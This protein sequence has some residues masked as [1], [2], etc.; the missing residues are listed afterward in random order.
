MSITK[1]Q[2]ERLQYIHELLQ[3]AGE[4]SS[5]ELLKKIEEQ[6][7]E[8]ISRRTLISDMNYL[9]EKGAPLKQRSRKY[10]YMGP[11]SFFQVL[12]GSEMVVFE[13][14]KAVISKL[15]SFNKIDKVLGQNLNLQL[16]DGKKKVLFD[17]SIENLGNS[18]LLPVLLDHILSED[19]IKI[20]YMDFA[21]Q[22]F[23]DK[24]HPYVLKEYNGRWYVFGLSEN[25]YKS[26]IKRIFQYAIDRIR[27][28][29]KVEKPQLPFFKN[30][31]WDADTHFA[32]MVGVTRPVKPEIKRVVV[33]IYG[34][35]VGYLESKPLH[36]TQNTINEEDQ[37]TD[38]EFRLYDNYEF[39]S[40]ILAL[41]SNAEVLEPEY[42]R[43]EIAEII[44][45]MGG[46]YL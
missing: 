42:L 34:T 43:K 28:I 26:G 32:N 44:Y 13:E 45:E 9:R 30:D 31:W 46:R 19:V 29:E 7:G 27:K 41:G 33:R 21:G 5:S 39:R 8:G 20:K 2:L 11:F 38:F 17:Y 37:Y 40:K 35:S 1:N 36:H 25:D 6:F 22:I 12:D 3:N 15:S 14:L 16:S 4:Y 23:E 18:E 24:F 10:K